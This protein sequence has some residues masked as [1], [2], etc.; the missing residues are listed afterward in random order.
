MDATEEVWEGQGKRAPEG[1]ETGAYYTQVGFDNRPHGRGDISP[2]GVEMSCCE[3][4]GCDAED[5]GDA[6]TKGP[7]VSA[8]QS[9]AAKEKDQRHTY[10]AP[11]VNTPDSAIFVRFGN[12]SLKI[13]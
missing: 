10:T 1:R 13:T 5:G 12:C 3:V 6:D 2:W 11:T 8:E 9:A 7:K 4:D